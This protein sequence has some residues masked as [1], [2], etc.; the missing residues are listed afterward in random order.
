MKQFESARAPHIIL[1][2]GI[3]NNVGGLNGK[4]DVMLRLVAR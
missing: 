1:N 2:I 3:A 4:R